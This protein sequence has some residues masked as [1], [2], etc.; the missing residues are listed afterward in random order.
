[1]DKIWSY[2]STKINA[3]FNG[4]PI[5]MTEPPLNPKKKREDLLEKMFEKF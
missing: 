2:C 3:T 5:L 4:S 1:M